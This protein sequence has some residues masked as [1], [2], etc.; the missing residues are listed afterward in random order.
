MAI[1]RTSS[2]G[3]ATSAAASP[4]T[5]ATSTSGSAVIANRAI[6]GSASG[7]SAMVT[8]PPPTIHAAISLTISAVEGAAGALSV[9]MTSPRRVPTDLT[10]CRAGM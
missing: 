3:T 4:P 6:S 8:M 5:R 1:L 9:A 7:N 10:R 2:T